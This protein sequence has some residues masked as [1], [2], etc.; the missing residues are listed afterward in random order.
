M[1]NIKT[2]GFFEYILSWLISYLS[3]RIFEVYL[4]NIY[5]KIC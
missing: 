3:K 5:Y 1:Q 2:K 4:D